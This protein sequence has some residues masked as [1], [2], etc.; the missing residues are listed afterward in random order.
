MSPM[1]ALMSALLRLG[2]SLGR[3]CKLLRRLLHRGRT[4]LVAS[5]SRPPR[6]LYLT[7]QG[8]WSSISTEFHRP[9]H[10]QACYS[11]H[12]HLGMIPRMCARH[13]RKAE[14]LWTQSGWRDHLVVSM[15]GLK[16]EFSQLR[17]NNRND[18]R[19]SCRSLCLSSIRRSTSL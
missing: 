18:R 4:S 6:H 5:Y 1:R 9:T 17:S 14:S 7:C 8:L 12:N 10:I 3:T 15:L 11:Q 13:R 2:A 16:F 19:C